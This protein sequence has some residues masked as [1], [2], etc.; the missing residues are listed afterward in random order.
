MA[1][2]KKILV[3]DDDKN[4]REDLKSSLELHNFEVVTALDGEDGLEKL[5][6]SDPDLIVCDILMPKI[7]G[8]ELLELVHKNDQ[9][10]NIP[11]IFLT[12]KT[13]M[14][15]LREGMELGADDYLPKPFDTD[16]LIQIINKRLDLSNIKTENI[17]KKVNVI[18]ENITKSLPHEILTPINGIINNSS[19][20][21]NNEKK[22]D[23]ESKFEMLDDII[24]DARRLHRLVDNYLYYSRLEL[25]LAKSALGTLANKTTN[26]PNDIIRS[27]L[28]YIPNKENFEFELQ[29]KN[30]I[31]SLNIDQSHFSKLF[32]E[33]IENAIKFSENSTKIV[34]LT[35]SN[36]D[37][38][39]LLI[40]NNGRGFPSHIKDFIGVFSQFEREIYEQQ[41]MGLG[42]AIC[43]KILEIYNGELIVDQEENQKTIVGFNLLLK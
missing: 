1:I 10:I 9:L 25:I 17:K 23:H 39:T 12:G 35:K 31:E 36:D 7:N 2:K 43:L 34:I 13:K 18:L 3:I 14:D 8:L 29:V 30:D 42:L 33:L 28:S 5:K 19:F 4:I 24:T 38:F 27:Y 26:K 16:K 41:G 20:L 37:H 22:L 15:D 40:K 32:Y 6:T 11:F 21:K